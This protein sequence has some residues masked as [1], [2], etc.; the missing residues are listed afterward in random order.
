MR[1]TIIPAFITKDG[2]PWLSFGVMGGDMQPQGHA[3]VLVNLLD[4]GADLQQAGDAPRFY[5][6]GSPEPTGTPMQE[7]GG[8]LHL[9]PDVPAA[10]ADAL[11]ARG[12]RIEPIATGAYGGYQAIWRDPQTGVYA[13]ATERRK[14]GCALGY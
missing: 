9:E 6:T 5:H 2:E 14:D 13:G 12:H 10:I 7:G 4:L 3:Q 8:V 1:D 11:R